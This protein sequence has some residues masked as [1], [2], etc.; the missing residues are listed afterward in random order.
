MLRRASF[1]LVFIEDITLP[2][3]V[4]RL[5][6]RRQT[7]G[8]TQTAA[9]GVSPESLGNISDGSLPVNPGPVTGGANTRRRVAY[10]PMPGEVR[11]SYTL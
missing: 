8:S 4:G 6:A 1:L 5:W 7:G 9:Y 10:I 3:G 2:F 11:D